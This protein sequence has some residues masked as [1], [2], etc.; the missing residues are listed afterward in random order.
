MKT[1]TVE[2]LEEAGYKDCEALF[3]KI[4]LAGGFGAVSPSHGGGLD[5]GG[6]VDADAKKAVAELLVKKEVKPNAV[7]NAG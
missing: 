2:A 5:V 7:T 1:V 3:T 4:A 6:I